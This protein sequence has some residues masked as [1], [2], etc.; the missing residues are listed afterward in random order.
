MAYKKLIVN[1]KTSSY[2]IYIG[3]NILL[4]TSKILKLSDERK[5]LIVTDDKIPDKHIVNLTTN[6]NNSI[7]IKLNSG[8]KNKNFENYQKILKTLVSNAFT[9]KDCIIALGGGMIGDITGFVASTY[10]RG[11]NFYNAPTTLL[12]QVD[13]S[14]G[15]KT[16]IN[17]MSIKNVI[18]SFYQPKAVLIDVDTL[19]TLPKREL[20]SGIVESIKMAATFDKDFFSYLFNCDDI[21]NNAEYII[22]K[23]LLIKKDVV[24]KDEKESSLRKVLNFGH[25]IGHAIEESMNYELL[26]GECVGLGML[27]FSSEKVRLMI[28]NILSKYDLP[29]HIHFDKDKIYNL[30]KHDKKSNG[31]TISTIHVLELG[32][33]KIVDQPLQKIYDLL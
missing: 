15:G 4:Q 6:L 13:S 30:I 26:H 31:D 33:Y 3:R 10:M 7:I 27:Y 12:S 17:F 22:H 5:Y 28:Q 9:R 18:G 24:E 32:T 14:I 19:K 2:P 21:L 1:L 29:T 11:M 23:S 8:E 20:H 16:A 25:T